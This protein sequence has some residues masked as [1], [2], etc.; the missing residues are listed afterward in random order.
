MRGLHGGHVGRLT[1]ELR[2]LV[3]AELGLVVTRRRDEAYLRQPA[4]QRHLAAFEADL[5]IAARTSTLAFDA[6]AAR[7]TE[8]GAAATAAPLVVET[9]ALRRV[10]IVQAHLKPPRPAACSGSSRSCRGSRAC[11]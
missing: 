9:A 8:P 4:L 3:H 10:E 11:P 5:V 7:L 6:A 1:R 2:E